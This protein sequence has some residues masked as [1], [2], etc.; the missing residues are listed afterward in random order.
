MPVS[1]VISV[2]MGT[3][4]STRTV[5]D[6]SRYLDDAITVG[7]VARS[8]DVDHRDFVVEPKDRG[9][10]ALGQRPVGRFDVLVRAWDEEGFEVLGIHGQRLARAPDPKTQNGAPRRAPRASV[11]G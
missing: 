7:I 11:L 10:G 3:S 6:G 9:A 4:G 2:G 1:L 8:L 5:K